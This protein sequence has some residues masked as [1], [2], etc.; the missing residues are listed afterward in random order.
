MKL[1]AEN[2]DEAVT[3]GEEKEKSLTEKE[4]KNGLAKEKQTKHTK[5]TQ[6]K[7]HR[8]ETT[9]LKEDPL[10]RGTTSIPRDYAM[11]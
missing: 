11:V 6:F 10:F 8:I 9:H 7:N 4:N 5:H 1:K 3:E 2:S